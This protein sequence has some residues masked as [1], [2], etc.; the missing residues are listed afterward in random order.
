MSVL[1]CFFIFIYFSLLTQA[2]AYVDPGTGGS[3]LQM[4]LAFF[5]AF[6][7]LIVFYFTKVKLLIKEFIKKFKNKSK[8]S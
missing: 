6:F 3:I 7:S 4:L 2:N 8:D 5:A 1:T